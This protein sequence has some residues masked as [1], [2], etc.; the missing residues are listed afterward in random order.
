MD[1]IKIKFLGKGI[2]KVN[3]SEGKKE[4]DKENCIL[5]SNK[6]A[7]QLVDGKNWEYNNLEE[8]KEI[9]SIEEIE[10]IKEEVEIDNDP[11]DTEKEAENIGDENISEMIKSLPSLTIEELHEMAEESGIELEELEGKGK[12]ALIKLIIK[13]LKGK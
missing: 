11:I 5:V 3:T 9:E 13:T 8:G 12:K 10:E 1:S 7:K 2:T 6:L 4:L